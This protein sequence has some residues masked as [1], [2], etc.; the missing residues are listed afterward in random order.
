MKSLLRSSSVIASVFFISKLA[1]SSAP[2]WT[3]NPYGFNNPQQHHV[4]QSN[5]ES[6]NG[7]IW[8]G[9]FWWQRDERG[10]EW[11]FDGH[12]LW[13]RCWNGTQYI[14]VSQQQHHVE[15]SNN[16]SHNGVIWDGYFWWQRDKHGREWHFDGLQLW[17][18]CGNGTQYI[19]VSQQQHH[20]E[21][22]NNESHNGV[23]WDGY[24]WWQRDKHGREWHF[25]GLQLW[26][27]CGNGT[28][29]IH[30]SQ[31]QRQLVQAQ[32][33]LRR[34]KYSVAQI[35]SDL[36]Y[37]RGQQSF[38]PHR[39]GGLEQPVE[40]DT[41]HEQPNLT[42]S[43]PEEAPPLLVLP[44]TTTEIATQNV[45]EWCDSVIPESQGV[46]SDSAGVSVYDSPHVPT[47]SENTSIASE[48]EVVVPQEPRPSVTQL[49]QTEKSKTL[50]ELA[51]SNFEAFIQKVKE[52]QKDKTIN[53]LELKKALNSLLQKEKFKEFDA[54]VVIFKNLMQE[55]KKMDGAKK[56]RE[57]AFPM[58][59]TEAPKPI[60]QTTVVPI[61]TTPPV[62]VEKKPKTNKE[63]AE[64]FI[65]D[66]SK[67]SD[68]TMLPQAVRTY[69]VLKLL[70]QK[71][72]HAVIVKFAHSMTPEAS[73]GD[74]KLLKEILILWINHH[75]KEFDGFKKSHPEMRDIVCALKDSEV[76]A[77]A[78]AALK[79][80]V[81][82]SEEAPV[83]ETFEVSEGMNSVNELD[84]LLESKKNTE[85][86]RKIL[87]EGRFENTVI[88]MQAD[89]RF[90]TPKLQEVLDH[91]FSLINY[92]AQIKDKEL[93]K[94]VN[95]YNYTLLWFLGSDKVREAISMAPNDFRA[96]IV[97]N[98]V[99]SGLNPEKK[100]LEKLIENLRWKD[101]QKRV[102]NLIRQ[103][104]T[105]KEY[106]EAIVKYFSAF[107]TTSS[108]RPVR[109]M[110][111]NEFIKI[112]FAN[113]Q[114]TP[115]EKEAKQ[116]E[117]K[118]IE[119]NMYTEDFLLK[120][121]YTEDF[122]L[123]GIEEEKK[124]MHPLRTLHTFKNHENE[125]VIEASSIDIKA[126]SIQHLLN[127]SNFLRGAPVVYHEILSS[128]H[129]EATKYKYEI[130]VMGKKKVFVLVVS[131]R[132]GNSSPQ[133][134]EIIS[135]AL[136]AYL[137]GKEYFDSELKR[138]QKRSQDQDAN[139]LSILNNRIA[140][141]QC[142]EDK[143]EAPYIDLEHNP[144]PASWMNVPG[145][146]WTQ[147]AFI[148]TAVSQAL[149][150]YEEAC[151]HYR[152]KREFDRTPF[153]REFD[154]TPFASELELKLI[155]EDSDR[156]FKKRTTQIE[157]EQLEAK[158]T[159]E[160]ENGDQVLVVHHPEE[161]HNRNKSVHTFV[162]TDISLSVIKQ[163]MT[164]INCWLKTKAIVFIELNKEV[165]EL[166]SC[167]KK[168]IEEDR[169]KLK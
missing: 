13:E 145:Q 166:T 78:W 20:V 72:T 148:V 165:A 99:G 98:L 92:R 93:K 32:E 162:L 77:R 62:K 87:V 66:L 68:L 111:R 115:Q 63:L 49:S 114:F 86:L 96:N 119:E 146:R 38:H 117:F 75:A 6:H 151:S 164:S 15:Q 127:P 128:N 101:F 161:E 60:V 142:L 12:Q 159:I 27:R 18:R 70:E 64:D 126:S 156:F 94:A 158:V 17:E 56:I 3:H 106:V 52:E 10:R 76:I 160:E 107:N 120:N 143:L 11:H 1:A 89:S 108:L 43:I 102:D 155:T 67:D 154:R 73:A 37:F 30:V 88:A 169:K 133:E 79:Q 167:I 50:Q 80:D 134:I 125:V 124:M 5:N 42:F 29:Y 130:H 136:L 45:T 113:F 140:L 23:I 40:A 152:F 24:F 9:Y 61:V 31:Q 84:L 147:A 90:S 53:V 39:E 26:E 100:Q 36:Q 41:I 47:P 85:V 109:C 138:L 132:S 123:K 21:Q 65:K 97:V 163:A 139:F 121:M 168:S 69:T 58:A 33:A 28:Q 19:H 153:K 135:T 46:A 144:I 141:V 74:K 149:S 71:S 54:F 131:H 104:T 35:E 14:H 81:L 8:D 44:V 83:E 91:F 103:K 82:L 110:I 116:K 55:F 129:L 150:T 57:R 2:S 4:E 34:R 22:S 157:T 7:V 105:A 25:D 118:E 51:L 95:A 122:P 137:G 112:L 48:N 16:E 59:P